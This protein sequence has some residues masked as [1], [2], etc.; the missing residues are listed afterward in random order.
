MTMKRR[1]LAV[2]AAITLSFAAA[3]SAGEARHFPAPPTVSP[4]MAAAVGGKAAPLWHREPKDMNEWRALADG[5][6]K[7]GAEIAI[8]LAE[9]LGVA[10][11]EEKIAGVAV[12]MLTPKTVDADKKDKII[13]FIHGGGYVLGGGPAGTTEGALMAS[14]G[15]YKVAAVD[16]RL[17]PE[18]PY[19]AAIDD[20]FAVYG[21]LVKKYGADNIAVL[22]TS[23]GGAMTLILALQAIESGVPLPAALMSGT[24]WSDIDKIGDSYAVNDGVDNV[25]GTYD[26]LL[27]AAAR[28]YAGGADLKDPLLSPVYAKD[29]ELAQFPPTLLFSGTRDLFL[30]NTAR[31]HKRLRVNGAKAELLVYEALSH[32][33]Y[34][35][36]PEAPETAEHYK[37][38]GMFLDEYLLKKE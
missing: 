33:Q 11:D 21:E 34:Y 4:E 32:A 13:Y 35:L 10:M 15:H 3:A 12:R 7:S 9:K 28:V 27:K 17:A 31:M 16:Y 2:T 37:L 5:F 8:K 6:A 20:A 26:Y 38:L 25:L 14:F 23:T 18:H 22:G 1:L 30:S 29:E 24:P 36:V 19:P